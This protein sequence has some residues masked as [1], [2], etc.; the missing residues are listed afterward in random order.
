MSANSPLIGIGMP[1]WNGERWVAD[2]VE[3]IRRQTLRD[4]ELVI[5]DNASTDRT[6]DVCRRLE[7]ADPRI[8][9]VCNPSNLGISV[10]HNRAFA[11]S[12]G[13]YFKWSACA[14]V[15]APDFLESC[16]ERLEASP[17]AVLCHSRTVMIDEAG[18]TI[19]G[20]EDGFALED[21]RPVARLMTYITRPARNNFVHGV[22]RRSVLS[23]T[24]LMKGFRQ[25]DIVLIADLALRGRF[26]L[27]DRPLFFRRETAQTDTQH[28]T[29]EQRNRYFDPDCPTMQWQTW[30]RFLALA[31]IAAT[32]PDATAERVLAA[33]NVA[34]LAWWSR[35]DLIRDIHES[36]RTAFSSSSPTAAR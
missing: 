2:T 24:S 22:I 4:W 13:T 20:Y 14:D 18:A 31:R 26:L 16:V 34:R 11:L 17:D 5:V 36:L 12:R 8:R 1:V 30:K 27:V 15:I 7:S 3:S 32:S 6:R 19:P 25:D 35:G 21:P 9:L 28:M 23:T 10:N 33:A 29:D